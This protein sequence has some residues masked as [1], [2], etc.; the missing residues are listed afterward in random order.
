MNLVDVMVACGALTGII[1]LRVK[2]YFRLLMLCV[3]IFS[4]AG[5]ALPRASYEKPRRHDGCF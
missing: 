5:T 1:Y 2:T 4:P 3:Q